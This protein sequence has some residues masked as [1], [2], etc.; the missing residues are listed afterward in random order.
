MVDRGTAPPGPD[1]P[2]DESELMAVAQL[3]RRL[4]PST[5]PSAAERDRMLRSIQARL[6][7]P[8][9]T[10][11]TASVRTD[12]RGPRNRPGGAD[13]GSTRPGDLPRP[14]AGARGRFA[15]AALA[16]LALVFSLAGMSLLL[17][18]DALPGDALYGIKRTAEAASLGLT[19]GDEPKALKHLE[20]AAARVNEIETLTQRFPNPNDAPVGNYLTALNDF[21]NDAAAGSRQLIALATSNDGRQLESLRAWAAQQAS[22]L[23]AVAPRLPTAARNRDAVTLGLLDK[24]AK[25]S[26]TLLARM[27]CYSITTGSADDI[28]ALPATGACERIPGATVTPP[29]ISAAPGSG[30]SQGTFGQPPATGSA[31][32]PTDATPTPPDPDLPVPSVSVPLPPPPGGGPGQSGTP[33]SPDPQP[34][35]EVV[36]P[37]PLPTVTVPP[38]LP[39]LPGIR[40]G[41]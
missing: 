35:P 25:R 7:T 21:D 24:I 32:P 30:S 12:T 20:F 26:E 1:G 38:V 17:A 5:A 27:Q 23:D 2:G 41:G 39:G 31:V 11:H 16:V 6:D 15:I 28:G 3:V 4:A 34:P 14:G 33:V 8:D 13:R 29:P 22:R 37:L 19:F 40:L 36:V 9:S 10:R 18:R